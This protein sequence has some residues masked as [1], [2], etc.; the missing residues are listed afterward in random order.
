VTRAFGL[1]SAS[2][3]SG[4]SATASAA[5]ASTRIA[6]SEGTEKSSVKSSSNRLC[7]P[8]FMKLVI[9]FC[10]NTLLG[11]TSMLFEVV[12]RRVVRQLISCTQPTRLSSLPGLSTIMIQ[13]PML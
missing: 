13:S 8:G 2:G 3:P 6:R 9:T 4:A 7:S 11:T 12:R 10:P 5:A 1:G